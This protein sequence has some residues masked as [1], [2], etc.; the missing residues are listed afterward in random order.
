MVSRALREVGGITELLIHTGQHFSPAMSSEFV[1]GLGMLEP[2]SNLGVGTM[3]EVSSVAQVARIMDKLS[4]AL[5]F[6]KPDLVLNYGDTNS[7]LATSLTAAKM[8]IPIAHVESGLRSG[9]RSQPEELNRIVC[10][11]LATYLF[12]PSLAAMLN[13]DLEGIDPKNRFLVGDVMLDSVIMHNGMNLIQEERTSGKYVLLT[14]HRPENTNGGIALSNV[15]RA[16]ASLRPRVKVVFPVH[17]RTAS[18]ISPAQWKMAKS[19]DWEFV[20]PVGYVE[21]LRIINH[22]ALV[23]T[24]SGGVQREAACLGSPCVVLRKVTEWVELVESGAVRCISPTRGFRALSVAFRAGLK[25]KKRKAEPP[26]YGNDSASWQ[27]ARVLKGLAPLLRQ[28]GKGNKP[29]RKSL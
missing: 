7:A 17:P 6:L 2:Y 29:H 25:K 11:H 16:L 13:L 12:V 26:P 22:A 27:I 28:A 5:H 3:A 20:P 8:G 15:F 1:Q 4:A 14:L 21:M 18:L 19:L 24:D 23:V 10:D 9:D